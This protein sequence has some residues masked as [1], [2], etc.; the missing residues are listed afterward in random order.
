MVIYMGI[1]YLLGLCLVFH[2]LRS[3]GVSVVLFRIATDKYGGMKGRFIFL[4]EWIGI[5][6]MLLFLS[7][8]PIC[9]KVAIYTNHRWCVSV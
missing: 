8:F 9:F 7:T 5:A 2:M 3:F 6:V 1:I 4:L